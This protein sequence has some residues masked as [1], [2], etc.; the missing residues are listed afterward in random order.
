MVLSEF[1][2]RPV[3]VR[4]RSSRCHLGV[5]VLGSAGLLLCG[6]CGKPAAVSNQL[7]ELE[8]AFPSAA[9]GAPASGPNAY[10]RLALAAARTNNYGPAI[11]ALQTVPRLPGATPQ[12]LMVVE[13][14]R[15]SMTA[16]LLARAA[17]GDAQAQAALAAIEKTRSQ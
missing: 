11:I 13:K 15:Q 2:E 5:L 17:K 16:D 4:G 6:G 1:G 14:V 7:S 9:T 3:S 10:V 12:Q 8:R